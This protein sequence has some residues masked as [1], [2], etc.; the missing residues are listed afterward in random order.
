MSK[1][2]KTRRNPAD[3]TVT[4]RVSPGRGGAEW[5]IWRRWVDSEAKSPRTFLALDIDH[6]A[7]V[8]MV[9][10]AIAAASGNRWA[11]WEDH[12]F[13]DGTMVNDPSEAMLLLRRAQ[14]RAGLH[15]DELVLDATV[16][17]PRSS[18]YTP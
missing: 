16:S 2:S 18:R 17:F 7:T 5:R 9:N 14:V 1:H 12:E 6:D 15:G 4:F 10:A 13:A 11:T 8:A 3:P